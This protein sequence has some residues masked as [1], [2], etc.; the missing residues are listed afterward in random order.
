[1]SW[2]LAAAALVDAAIVVIF[3]HV[4]WLVARRPSSARSRRATLAFSVWW[5]GIGVT[6]LANAAKEAVA[7]AGVHDVP[8]V[9]AVLDAFQFAYV[10][11]LV[12]AVGGLVAYLTYLFTGSRRSFGPIAA[13]YVAYGIAALWLVA[14]MR[15]DGVAPGKWF[16]QWSYAEPQAGGSLLLLMVLL[17]L[18][19][20]IG[21]A[22]AYL[23]LR[24]RVADGAV[25][26]RAGLVG[27]SLLLWQGIQLAAPFLQLGRFEWW[28]AGGRLVGLAAAVVVLLAYRPPRSVRR[29]IAFEEVH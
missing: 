28:Q 27:W 10:A 29:R 5:A 9:V 21:A 24:R 19:P 23:S 8:A 7:A 14:R 4:A 17:L 13:F 25:R 22:A 6:I 3:L 26:Y 16:V 1:M 18:L 15:P 11:A 20:Q 2:T 12:A